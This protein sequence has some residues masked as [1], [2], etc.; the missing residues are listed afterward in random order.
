MYNPQSKF[1]G[2]LTLLILQ[3]RQKL[4]ISY[5]HKGFNLYMTLPLTFNLASQIDLLELGLQNTVYT[6]LCYTYNTQGRGGGGV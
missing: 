3:S 6:I 5:L 4:K 1:F 2:I